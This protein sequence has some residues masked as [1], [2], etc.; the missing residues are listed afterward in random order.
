MANL[1]QVNPGRGSSGA[2][3]TELQALI[4][5][6][7][8][9]KRYYNEY[10]TSGG[11]LPSGAATESTLQSVLAAIA[12]SQDF[13]ILLVRDTGAAD[14]VIKEIKEYDQG[15]GTLTTRYED[16]S[17]GA[18]VPVGPLEYLDPA[19]T[20]NLLLTEVLDQGVTLDN[21]E[22]YTLNES[23]ATIPSNSVAYTYYSGVVAGNPS[24]NVNL[25]TAAYSNG[26]GV[27]YT[28]TFFYDLNDNVISIVVT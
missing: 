16:V 22:T 12:Q 5:I 27:V 17:G 28:Q 1:N 9:W 2:R 15:T 18:Y 7:R 20:L 23:W 8:Q 21:I 4:D 14:V 11:A 25:E 6:L 24:G 3:H 19:G 26:G 13:E 10:V